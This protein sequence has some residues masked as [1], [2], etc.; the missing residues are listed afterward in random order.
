M[1]FCNECGAPRPEQGSCESCGVV[2]APPH[3]PRRVP[4]ARRHNATVV[5]GVG[6]GVLVAA[7]VAGTFLLLADAEKAAEATGGRP[8][9]VSAVSVD[10]SPAG[11]T[12]KPSSKPE[13][14]RCWDRTRVTPPETCA[15]ESEE[16]QF[17]A[18]GLDRA[19]CRAAP[20]L[21][22]THNR[23][24]YECRVRGVLVHLATYRSGD[25]AA[26]LSSYG[27]RQDLGN[28]RILAGGPTSAAG[29]WLRTY[30]DA[31][32]AKGLLMYASVEALAPRDR[33]VLLG[34]QQRFADELLDG[35]PI[36][37]SP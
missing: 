19:T 21:G 16:A 11:P 3:P 30:G 28:G 31:A 20:E 23:W 32:A 17:H 25:R 15:V 33:R 37:V 5:L 22:G 14:S 8:G 27:A 36:T 9:G 1:R 13:S 2:H 10:P 34:L 35:D 4:A 24:S 7:L 29:R 18:F 6:V 12:P 26:R